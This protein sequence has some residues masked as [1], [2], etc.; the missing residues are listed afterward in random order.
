MG[1]SVGPIARAPEPSPSGPTP[2]P[3][4]NTSYW[5][6][7]W[8]L[9]R[10]TSPHP[11]PHGYQDVAP[12]VDRPRLGLERGL[13]L[14]FFFLWLLRSTSTLADGGCN[15][16]VPMGAR[17]GTIPLDI[18]HKIPHITI[19]TRYPPNPW[20]FAP[21]PAP[22]F[23]PPHPTSEPQMPITPTPSDIGRKV[24]Y[25]ERGTHAG[26]KVEEG[27]LTSYSALVAFV[28]YGTGTTSAAT[29]PQYLEWMS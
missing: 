24:I 4:H 6:P 2:T 29:N 11:R 8:G 3:R 26:R 19:R 5:G 14:I 10:G 7:T 27:V 18:P 1:C 23:S 9:R 12:P 16:V 22:Q 25:R 17:K 20:R 21:I 13:L 15:I 28:R